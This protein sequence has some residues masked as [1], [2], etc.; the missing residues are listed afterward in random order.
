MLRIIVFVF[1][2]LVSNFTLSQND[3][4]SGQWEKILLNE[5]GENLVT[6]K[7]EFSSDLLIIRIIK[8]KVKETIE[9]VK[10]KDF[11]FEENRF[12]VKV[13]KSSIVPQSGYLYGELKDGCLYINAS[14]NKLSASDAENLKSWMKYES[15]SSLEGE[16]VDENW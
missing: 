1:I 4:F 16:N 11:L 9:E 14:P 10:I 12:R 6:M 3:L 2:I 8:P 15:V 7:L 13:R 5:G